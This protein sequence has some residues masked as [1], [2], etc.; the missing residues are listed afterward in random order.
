M[1][2]IKKKR[3]EDLY[4]EFALLNVLFR[5][6]H[7]TL[8]FR[9]RNFPRKSILETEFKKTIIDFGISTNKYHFVPNFTS[10]KAL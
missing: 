1:L 8:E 10:I 9:E 6:K 4:L 7:R 5:L 2:L 3:I